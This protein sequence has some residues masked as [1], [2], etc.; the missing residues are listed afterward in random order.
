MTGHSF[1]TMILASTDKEWFSN[2]PS[3]SEDLQ[4][5]ETVLSHLLRKIKENL[6]FSF[7]TFQ[8]IS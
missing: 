4:S 3:K 8:R 1:D 7:C 6:F 5:A 2:D